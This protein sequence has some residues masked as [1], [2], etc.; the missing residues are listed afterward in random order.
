MTNYILNNYDKIIRFTVDRFINEDVHFLD[1]KIYQNNTDI[2]YKDTHTVQYSH[3]C[4]QT[5]QKLKTSW[6]KVLYHCAN[7][8]LSINH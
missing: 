5:R 2:Y 8:I 1:I 6:I 7:K 3:Y 4:S